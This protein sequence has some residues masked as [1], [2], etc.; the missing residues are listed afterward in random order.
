MKK[1]ISILYIIFL[2]SL[3]I[4]YNNQLINRVDANNKKESVNLLVINSYHQGHYWESFV[5]E[6]LE[7][8]L[9]ENSNF[10][11]NIKIE[12]LDFRN[13]ND[14]AYQ[15]S[16]KEML[17]NKYPKGSIDI[18]CSVND[19]AYNFIKDNTVEESSV[20]YNLP[21]IFCG[22]DKKSE[23]V[24]D[25]I[26]INLNDTYNLIQLILEL[27]P[28][29]ENLNLIVEDSGYGSAVFEEVVKFI[30]YYSNQ[31]IDITYIKGDY[32]EE[33]ISQLIGQNYIPNS[34]NIVA[35]EFQYKESGIFLKPEDTIKFIQEYNSSPIFSNDQTYLKAGIVGG[36]VDTGQ[37]HGEQAADLIIKIINKEDI[38]DTYANSNVITKSYIDYKG[39]YKYGID[40]T[41][42]DNDMI[43]FNK[44]IY[45]PMWSEG[46]KKVA[47][48]ILAII[49]L[50]IF[51]MVKR[52]IKIKRKYSMEQQLQKRKEDRENLK[53]DFIVNLSH[54]L[55][56]PINIIVNT[57]KVI[58]IKLREDR[59]DKESIEE[60]L[61]IINNNSYRLLKISNNIIDITNSES[62]L[63]KLVEKNENIVS[64]VEEA[65]ISSL[66]FSK[67]KNIEMIFD[68]SDEE[69]ITGI[70]KIQMQRVMLNL[71]SNAIK[72]TNK[73]GS[74]LVTVK[75]LSDEVEIIV[76]D[77]GIG[78]PESKINEI[79]HR[80]YQVDYS[81]NRVNEGSGIG[82]CIVKDIVEYH[83][84]RIVVNS[85]VGK[86]SEF[87]IYLPIKILNIDI[88]LNSD[89]SYDIS[90]IAR[91]EMSDVN[92]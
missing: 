9:K 49:L 80:F 50:S 60:K 53:S 36:C 31:N 64:V 37:E 2:I 55:R 70:D 3:I 6:G 57:T 4:F 22:V 29:V 62:G 28:K 39:L 11:V 89:F 68:T 69:I 25:E 33:I 63:F 48:S 44:K 18:L 35:G 54:E 19:E 43:V 38:L 26:H 83:N 17:E 13:R 81:I 75:E 16:F 5:I 85:K 15:K 14:E 82:L 24:E 66:E 90:T 88:E 34:V 42:V 30:N 7:K 71:L 23:A 76:K 32:I 73:G 72:Y 59:V 51:I 8:K 74:I 1:K 21:T 10:D 61:D 40:P 79:F 45:E 91:V 12:Y 65:F 41:R 46:T 86:G 77:N 87:K 56:T 27:I 78:I 92:K 58:K 52:V 84:G 67:L 20:F 47:L